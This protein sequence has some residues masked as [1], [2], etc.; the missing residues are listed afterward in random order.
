MSLEDEDFVA[1]R[2]RKRPAVT[3]YLEDND[4]DM[5]FDFEALSKKKREK[6]IK[7]AGSK[8][9]KKSMSSKSNVK[10]SKV[11]T[12]TQDQKAK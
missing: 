4:F 7:E 2:K 5:A 6:K 8:S 1:P 3:S 11:V 10:K 9:E 12:E